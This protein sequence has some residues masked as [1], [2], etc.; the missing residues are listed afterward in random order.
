MRIVQFTRFPF[1]GASFFVRMRSV[2][3]LPVREKGNVRPKG[4]KEKIMRMNKTVAAIAVA[5]ICAASVIGCGSTGKGSAAGIEKTY[6]VSDNYFID[7]VG[8]YGNN[9]TML[10]LNSN[11]TYDLYY[12]KDLFGT[13]DPG[14]KG[15]KTMIYSGKYTSAASADGEA[16]HLDI[17]LEAPT[18]I[19]M[20]QHGKA[21]GRN[22]IAGNVLLDTANW[23]DAM[24]TLVF[25]EGNEDGA[26]AFLAKYAKAMTVTVEDP[27]LVPDDTTLSYSIVTVPEVQL[28]ITGNEE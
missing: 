27:S 2:N 4:A 10:V 13:T 19:Y 7:Q 24:T 21:F 6:M 25:P 5:A 26:K 20:E 15:N 1:S 14:I 23:T 16:S 3:E 12:K 9:D 11:E 22:A 28:E 8:W 17:S 18:R